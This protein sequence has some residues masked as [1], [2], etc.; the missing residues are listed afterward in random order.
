MRLITIRFSHFCEKARWG[1]DVC[2]IPY[3]EDGHLPAFHIKPLKRAQARGEKDAASSRYSVPTL[4]LDD[5][6][7][8]TDSTDIL[9]Y[10]SE[11]SSTHDLYPQTAARAKDGST[12]LELERRFHDDIA[13][14]SRRLAYIFLLND[15]PR[16]RKLC[17]A[18]VPGFES[19]AAA[20]AAPF[21]RKRMLDYMGVDANAQQES[22]QVIES[23]LSDVDALVTDREFLVGEQLTAADISFA[24][25]AAP[26]LV[27]HSSEGY[28]AELPAQADLPSAYRALVEKWRRTRA[29]EYALNLYKHHRG[30]RAIAFGAAA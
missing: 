21:M 27:V 29:A 23:V 26:A 10:A 13:I 3:V 6:S 16:F 24:A 22:I 7:V 19:I 9:K 30:T 18:N 2:G 8:L 20:V 4:V 15:L 11:Q 25:A 5:G 17:R 28:G 1:L 12:I 14:H